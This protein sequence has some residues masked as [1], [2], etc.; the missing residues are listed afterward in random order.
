MAVDGKVV[1]E[2]DYDTTKAKKSIKGLNIDLKAT[3]EKMSS[4]GS[5]MTQ[6]V[7]LPIVAGA[8]AAVA[9]FMQLSQSLDETRKSAIGVGAGVE[10]LQAL[11]FAGRKAG[12]ENDKLTDSLKKTQ[13]SIASNEMAFWELGIATRDMKNN[14]LDTDIVFMDMLNTLEGMDDVTRNATAKNLGFTEE[15][16]AINQLLADSNAFHKDYKAGLENAVTEEEINKF[17]KFND[18]LEDIKASLVPVATELGT[19]VLPYFQEFADWF[20]SDGIDA[21]EKGLPKL[22]DFVEQ[23]GII[24]AGIAAAG[25]ALKVAGTAISGISKIAP[26]VTPATGGAVAVAGLT[27]AGWEELSEAWESSERAGKKLRD[28][29]KE[30][31]TVD[32]DADPN[33]FIAFAEDVGDSF[34]KLDG[35]TGDLLES[36]L[37]LLDVVPQAY[38]T[39]VEQLNKI[40]G[41]N[42]PKAL[43]L[44]NI[45]G[46]QSVAPSQVTV[47][48]FRQAEASANALNINQLTMNVESPMTPGNVKKVGNEVME[49]MST[50]L[51]TRRTW[52]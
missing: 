10:G 18:T 30:I 36:I 23:Y 14:A 22:I 34:E 5:A 45:F 15:L 29:I 35:I 48:G 33:M 50:Q 2:V 7:T 38:N 25:P 20:E 9:G 21:V 31:V 52:K 28:A 6:N 32:E 27:V 26:L 11:Q 19:T 46:V 41:I 39:I 40:D 17:E 16:V 13:E 12:I 47:G 49:Y 51:Q 37:S 3:G 24:I 42:L 1:Y 44:E 8:G 4:I 43:K